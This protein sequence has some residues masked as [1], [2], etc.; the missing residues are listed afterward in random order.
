MQQRTAASPGGA[1]AGAAGG[2]S[3]GKSMM[4]A[5][6]SGRTPGKKDDGAAI[7]ELQ[8]SFSSRDQTVKSVQFDPVVF[9]IPV[10]VS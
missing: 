3:I 5:I 9:I 1:Q 4:S 6:S 2:S 10:V 8:V 7:H